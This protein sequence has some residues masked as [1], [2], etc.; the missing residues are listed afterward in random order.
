MRSNNSYH[1]ILS[2]RA[3]DRNAAFM[4]IVANSFAIYVLYVIIRTFNYWLY[5]FVD[6]LR[7]I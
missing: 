3:F 7:Q 4:I 5:I 6:A 2:T 1:K